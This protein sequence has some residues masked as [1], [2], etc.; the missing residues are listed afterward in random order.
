MRHPL[1]VYSD[2]L[3]HQFSELL[4]VEGRKGSPLGC[5]DHA[6]H[7]HVGAKHG[8]AT[9]AGAVT[10]HALEQLQEKNSIPII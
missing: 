6:R 5:A 2:E 8:E 10:F 4:S 7:V 3:H 9:I 1:L